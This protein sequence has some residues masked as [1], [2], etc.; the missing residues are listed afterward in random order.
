MA[1]YHV[2]VRKIVGTQVSEL[3]INME[4]DAPINSEVA[5]CDMERDALN[6]VKQNQGGEGWYLA[7]VS[8][9]D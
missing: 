1:F 6:G 9:L 7:S 8:R 3:P 2:L 4:T 5:Y